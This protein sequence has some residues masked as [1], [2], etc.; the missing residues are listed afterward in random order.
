MDTP[1]FKWGFFSIRCCTAAPP[2]QNPMTPI[3]FAPHWSFRYLRTT[4]TSLRHANESELR[5]CPVSLVSLVAATQRL[6]GHQSASG[7]EWLSLHHSWFFPYLSNCLY[8]NPL[9][10]LL[11]FPCSLP[12]LLVGVSEWSRLLAAGQNTTVLLLIS[13]IEYKLQVRRQRRKLVFLDHC[14]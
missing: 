11:C 3:F 4:S 14:Y 5:L 10:F 13:K 2:Q 12:L 6:G 9:V 7:M 8:L 1:V